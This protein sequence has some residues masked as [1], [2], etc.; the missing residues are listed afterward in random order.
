M[1]ATLLLMEEAIDK[2]VIKSGTGESEFHRRTDGPN[3]T[4]DE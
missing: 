1:K 3:R 2:A 4:E